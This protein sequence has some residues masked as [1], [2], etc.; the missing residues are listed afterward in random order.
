MVVCFFWFYRVC[1]STV[2]NSILMDCVLSSIVCFFQISRVCHFF[3]FWV[4]VNL[5][6]RRCFVCRCILKV[7]CLLICLCR[8]LHYLCLVSPDAKFIDHG[9]LGARIVRSTDWE[10]S[11]TRNHLCLHLS[12]EGLVLRRLYL[13]SVLERNVYWSIGSANLGRLSHQYGFFIGC[14]IRIDFLIQMGRLQSGWLHGFF[15]RFLYWFL[16]EKWGALNQLYISTM[17]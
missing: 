4:P 7:F 6:W 2:T 1:Q 5:S 3:F 13:A 11:L 9:E 10:I 8:C 17:C 15:S 16:V 14:S 12:E